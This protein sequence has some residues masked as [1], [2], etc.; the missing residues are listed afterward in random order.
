MRAQISVAR[1][2]AVCTQPRDFADLGGAGQ[3][4]NLN[5]APLQKLDQR[6]ADGAGRPRQQN[7]HARRHACAV[8]HAFRRAT[9]ARDRRKFG[10]A[11]VAVDRN[12]LG[13]R[14]LDVLRIGA[15]EIRSHP[16]VV[17]PVRP[18]SAHATAH[19]RALTDP[20]GIATGADRDHLAATVRALV[21]LKG[22]ATFQPPS[23]R[24]E[25]SLVSAVAPVI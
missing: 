9:G 20:S 6:R 4:G 7:P 10:V 16:D 21:K 17:H 5:L 23:L 25:V 14:H 22:V 3:G 8:D 13:L 11:S 12:G 1:Q 15:V 2:P 24:S 19:K 18:L